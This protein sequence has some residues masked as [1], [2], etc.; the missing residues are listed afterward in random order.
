MWLTDVDDVW[1][2]SPGDDVRGAALA[3]LLLDQTRSIL[4]NGR[5]WRVGALAR[6]F[7]CE[8]CNPL[9]KE[10]FYFNLTGAAARA[11]WTMRNTVADA[12]VNPVHLQHLMAALL[13]FETHHRHERS[14]WAF[15]DAYLHGLQHA[16]AEYV[17]THNKSD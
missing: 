17:R 16:L 5:A 15:V 4:Q 8:P 1:N 11:R 10:A 3:L 7:A 9:S 2:G 12:E 6:T 13:H 14:G